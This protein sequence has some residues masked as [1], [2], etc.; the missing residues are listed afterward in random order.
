MFVDACSRFSLM[1]RRQLA[2]LTPLPRPVTRLHLP[3]PYSKPR[4]MT[5]QPDRTE[6]SAIQ[7]QP[8]TNA[9]NSSKTSEWHTTTSQGPAG[10]DVPPHSC[11]KES[12]SVLSDPADLGERFAA[13]DELAEEGKEERFAEPPDRRLRL[14]VKGAANDIGV[15]FIEDDPEAQICIEAGP[16]LLH[17]RNFSREASLLGLLGDDREKQNQVA[18]SSGKPHA[19][20]DWPILP[21]LCLPFSGLPHP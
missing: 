16:P 18:V 13:R 19:N 10:V 7:H 5:C 4:T 1:S 11:G 17:G 21:P 2:S 14:D 20:G 8:A 6:Q 15:E 12:Q 3:S 9:T